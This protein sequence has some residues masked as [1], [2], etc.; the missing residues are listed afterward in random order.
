MAVQVS[1]DEERRGIRTAHRRA[2]KLIHPD[3][4]TGCAA[5]VDSY[6]SAPETVRNHWWRTSRVWEWG[7]ATKFPPQSHRQS[8]KSP[9]CNGGRPRCRSGGNLS[10]GNRRPFGRPAPV[11]DASQKTDREGNWSGREDSNLRPPGPEPGA[12]A[13]LSHAPCFTSLAIAASACRDYSARFSSSANPR[14]PLRRNTSA[15]R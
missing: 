7:G 6:A 15:R 3:R 13:R 8:R 1:S 4:Q 5:S 12:L 9:S 14:I 11:C 2:S 10:F